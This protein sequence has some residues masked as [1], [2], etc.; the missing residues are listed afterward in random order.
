[1][2]EVVSTPAGISCPPTCAARFDS[3][4]S[5]KLESHSSAQTWSGACSGDAD[6]CSIVV[7]GPTSVTDNAILGVLA[8]PPPYPLN[9]T[10]SGRGTISDTTHRITGCTRQS[11]L[12]CQ[13]TFGRGARVVLTASAMHGSTFVGWYGLACAGKSLRCKLSVSDPSGTGVAA[14][15]TSG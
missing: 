12:K 15:F 7:D 4:T 9:I 8:A 2:G 3:G 1:L 14:A 6:T 5:V 13:T 10:V 11:E